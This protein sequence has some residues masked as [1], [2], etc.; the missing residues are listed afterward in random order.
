MIGITLI[1]FLSAVF[2]LF[3]FFWYHCCKGGHPAHRQS[4]MEWLA[5]NP[6]VNENARKASA[7]R[8]R[9]TNM[10]KCKDKRKK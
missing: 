2:I 3:S 1:A 7:K 9:Q 5:A 4:P 10:K 6:E 8:K